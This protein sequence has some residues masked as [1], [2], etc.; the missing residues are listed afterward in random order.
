VSNL[1]DSATVN[2]T[3]YAVTIARSVAFA[4]SGTYG[5]DVAQRGARAWRRR[6]HGA[7]TQHLADLAEEMRAE[8]MKGGKFADPDCSE[9]ALMA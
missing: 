9:I 4:I 8:V 5:A 7:W 1:A 2:Y 3:I 6:R